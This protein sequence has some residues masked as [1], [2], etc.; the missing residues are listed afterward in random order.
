MRA[1]VEPSVRV[2]TQWT[3]EGIRAAEQRA[4]Y[5]DL[6]PAADLCDWLLG[7]DRIG[8]V[9]HSRTQSLLGLVPAFEPSGDGRRKTRAVNALEAQEDWWT[10]YP[11]PELNLMMTWGLL[12]GIAPMRHRWEEFSDHQGRVLPQPGFWHPQHL[13]YDFRTRKWLIKVQPSEALDGMWREEELVPGDSTWI[14]HTPYGQNRPWS[15][16]LWR[17]LSRWALLKTLAMADWSRTSANSGILTATAP[18]EAEGFTK[19][20]RSELADDIY[21]RGRNAVAALPPGVSLDLVAT[22]ANTEALFKAQIDLA[23]SVIAIAIKGGNLST[24]V[25]GGSL[26]AA[27]SQRESADE[28]R[29]KFD[30]QSLVCTIHDQS[31]V[32]WAEFN[33]GDRKLAPW[34]VYPVEADEDVDKK[35]TAVQKAVATAQQLLTLGFDVNPQ[36]F[37]DEFELSNWVISP[38]NGKLEPK[39]FQ[40]AD[41]AFKEAADAKPPGDKGTDSGS[42]DKGD[43]KPEQ[44]PN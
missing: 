10:A 31:L 7:D 5:G 12:L 28:P 27:E 44:R 18:Y 36:G 14:L 11:E 20:V 8:P 30:A 23:N 34:P 24:E 3:P 16:G 29:L 33:F 15:M 22:S 41:Q 26:A 37:I 39:I 9:L 38:A 6:R 25:K 2:F 19:A 4:D 43:P 13:R 32:W 40:Q 1:G 17:N 42:A 21:N 35:I